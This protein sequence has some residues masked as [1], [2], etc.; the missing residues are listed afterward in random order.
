[1]SGD[2]DAGVPWRRP[3]GRRRGG[4]GL[5]RS[6]PP[7]PPAAAARAP[8]I[9]VEPPA[10]DFGS[11]LPEKRSQKEFTLRNL[12]DEDLV[13]ENVST[14]CG[15]TVAERLQQGRQARRQHRRCA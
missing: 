5:A 10:F 11:A 9:A 15:C 7:P 6:S 4:P 3:P 8:R 12:G 14:T 1:M 2:L 13:I